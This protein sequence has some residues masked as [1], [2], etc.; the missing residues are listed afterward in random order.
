[1]GREKKRKKKEKKMIGDDIYRTFGPD[2]LDSKKKRIHGLLEYF[3]N[4]LERL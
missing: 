4:L 1:M 2:E 3:E